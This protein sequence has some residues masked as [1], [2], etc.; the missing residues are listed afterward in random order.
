MLSRLHQQVTRIM[1]AGACALLATAAFAAS[2][3]ATDGTVTSFDGTKI[4]Y[5]FF[6]D[7]S[8]QNGAT[9]PTVMFGPGY[10]SARAN[11]SDPTVQ[12]LLAAGYNVLTWDPRGFGD[13]EGDVELDSPAFEARDVSALIDRIAQQPQAQ[14]DGPND[15]RVGMVGASYG[16]GIQLTSA[17]IDPRIDV[18]APQIAWNSLISALDKSNTAKGGWGSLLAVLGAEGS[19]TGG[20]LGG[21]EGDPNGLQVGD[22]QD[23]RIYT[24]LEDGLTTGEFTA[25]DQSFF[26]SA[27]PAPLLS[28]IHIP[29]L[30][31]QGTDDTLFSLH[32]A[33]TNYNALRANGVPVQMLW[34]CGSLTDDPGV[35]HGQCLTPKG[36]D[37]DITLHF[38]LRWLARYLKRDTSVDTGPGFTWISDAG[39][40]RTT[41]SYPPA[42]GAPVTGSGSGT[43]PLVPGDVSG[44]LIVASRAANA[45]NVPL[46]TPAAGTEMVGEP[47]L[48]LNYS[49]T[50]TNS[51]D[52]LY[53][54]IISNANGLVLGNQVT[55]IP[56]T[57]D[58]HA[59]TLTIPLEAVAADVGAGSTYT[60]QITDGTDVYFAAR[61][62]GLVNLSKISV[63]VPT[64]APG[65][66]Q[67][68]TGITPSGTTGTGSTTGSGSTTGTGGGTGTGTK[69]ATA[70]G[71][72]S[73]VTPTGRITGRSLGPVTLGMTR[74][75]A[76]RPFKSFTTRGRRY[77][78]F[79]CPTHGGI[80]VGYASPVL[81][82]EL[83]T[84]QRATTRNRAVLILTANHHYAIKGVRPATH[85]S[86]AR[87]RLKLERP[88][89]VGRNDWYLASDGKIRAVLKV[90]HGEIDEIGIASKPLTATRAS[91]A[92]FL[93]TF[94]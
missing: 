11:S 70:L 48:T 12:A 2:A 22:M 62:A 78:D 61:S 74:A 50:A 7:P 67:V 73:C 5:S 19:T 91:A 89:H 54:Q 63:S 56:V 79:F 83:P 24:A 37:T 88:F 52:R 53:A 31:M 60:L 64:V 55:P 85:L 44:E 87:R 69:R 33:I 76:R 25:A 49:G 13:S 21:L 92:K 65:A 39:V 23:P 26:A 28:H 6:P 43:L 77:M 20:V 27:G 81:L 4:V 71:S 40:E 93:R 10:G 16:G 75:R 82:R 41:P 38:E 80:R 59:H 42:P 15:P 8:L 1:L 66:S 3:R 46:Q 18:I 30:L 32:E 68:V 36:P 86:A 58:G 29:V 14:L 47:T 51:D 94:S 34:F 9:A 90:R 35:A 45:V 57:L 72:F 84:R 17:E